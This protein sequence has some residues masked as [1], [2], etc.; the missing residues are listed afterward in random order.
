MRTIL[1]TI[2]FLGIFLFF[3]NTYTGYHPS[4]Y[5][6]ISGDTIRGLC[7]HVLDNDTY[8]VPQRVFLGDTVFVHGDMLSNFFE[9][10]HPLIE[11]PYIL[12][13]HHCSRD[14]DMALPGEHAHYLEDKKI[15]AWFVKNMD[16]HHPKLHPL[17]LGLANQEYPH[18]NIQTI[19]DI[20]SKVRNAPKNALLYMNFGLG[21]CYPTE[22][23][24]VFDM[25]E[26]ERF[27][28]V[29]IPGQTPGEHLLELSEHKFVLSPRGKG[30]DCHRTWEALLMGVIPIVKTSTIDEMYKDLPILIVE[31]WSQVTEE[32][33][34][35][36][37][38]SMQQKTYN[39]EKMFVAYWWN[40][41]KKCQ[42][43]YRQQNH[44]SSAIN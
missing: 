30:L 22:R 37:Y 44:L 35:N 28:T 27:C 10:Y 15:I 32:F 29:G 21:D 8:L 3:N 24:E 42:E 18:G 13:T 25:F 20:M 9:K 12:V 16:R 19:I 40:S 11:N 33:L 39:Q 38:I 2:L 1:K 17:P 41:I 4:G 26:N 43:N 7:D 5:P 6:F 34:N 31:N 14:G 36:A 23:Q